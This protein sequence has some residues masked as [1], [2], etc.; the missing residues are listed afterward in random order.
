MDPGLESGFL[1][2][3]QIKRLSYLFKCVLTFRLSCISVSKVFLNLTLWLFSFQS[4]LSN[5]F[6]N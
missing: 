5:L 1:Y 6:Y 4:I 2:D 3:D